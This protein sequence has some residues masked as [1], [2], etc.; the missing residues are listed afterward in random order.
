MSDKIKAWMYLLSIIF[1]FLLLAMIIWFV[2]DYEIHNID[3][4]IKTLPSSTSQVT[5]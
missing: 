5:N 4:E 3:K 1:I 2:Y